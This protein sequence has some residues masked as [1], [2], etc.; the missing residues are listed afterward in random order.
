MVAIESY[1]FA[2]GA[3]SH[4]AA[5]NDGHLMATNRSVPLLYPKLKKKY[6]DLVNNLS[7]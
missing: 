3:F 4:Y 7:L 2:Q 6:G 1:A 5:D